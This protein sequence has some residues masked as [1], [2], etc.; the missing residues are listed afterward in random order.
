LEE[1]V[2]GPIQ[3]PLHLATPPSSLRNVLEE[4][5]SLEPSAPSPSATAIPHEVDSKDRMI[6]EFKQQTESVL[7]QV[8]EATAD[9][10]EIDR[11]DAVVNLPVPVT[12]SIASLANQARDFRAKLGY[13]IAFHECR[14]ETETVDALTV[15]DQITRDLAARNAPAVRMTLLNFLKRY[16]EPPGDNQK[17]LWRYLTS[18]L[19]LENQLKDDAETH[20]KRAQSLESAG[21]KIEAIQ[22]YQEINRI[23]PN[24][25]TAT[26]I[27]QL[28]A[29]PR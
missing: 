9:F 2:P 4:A 3:D 16:P 18:A 7:A 13:E 17:R 5:P 26:K 11:I 23:Y 8:R 27:R 22:E 12:I 25:V 6:A 21:K 24:P 14:A 28:E 20:L 10:H 29:Q 1:V 19:S 15:V